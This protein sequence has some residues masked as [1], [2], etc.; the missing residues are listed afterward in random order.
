MFMYA[1]FAEAQQVPL[2][3]QYM[4][5]GFL[6]NP[7]VAGSE[8]Y[9]AVNLTVREQWLGLKDAPKTQALS[10][11]TRMLKNS[12]ISKNSS[13][14]KRQRLSSRSGNIGLGAIYFQ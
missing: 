4:M 5:N 8:G 3:S 14:R 9:T 10:G 1:S 6:L 7:A 12:F 11:Q 13:I 2:Y